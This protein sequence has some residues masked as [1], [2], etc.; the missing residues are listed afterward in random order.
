MASSL[1][2]YTWKSFHCAYRIDRAEENSDNNLG[3]LLIHPIGVGLSGAFWERFSQLWLSQGYKTSI[4]NPDLL[5]CG[6]SDM[7]RMAYYPSDWA[8]QLNFFLETV[9][10]TPVVLVVQGALFPVAIELV[11]NQPQPNYIKGLILSGPPTWGLISEAGNEWQQKLVWNLFFDTPA[12][13]AFYRYARRRQF[14]ES[15]SKKQLFAEAEA[16]DA[17]WLDN[18]E[19]GAANPDSRYAVFS[20]LAGFWRQNYQAAIAKITQPTL[21]VVGEKA[22]SISR[23]GD[24]ET[25]ATRL[26]SY[27]KH[28][29]NGKGCQISGRNVPPY[30][31]TEEFVAV[32]AE[33]LEGTGEQ[34]SRGTGEQGRRGDRETGRRGDQ[35]TGSI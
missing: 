2:Y 31:S 6:A 30:E 22:S 5:G 21:V 35:E 32:V 8:A 28:L 10:K 24:S 29:P 13:N 20:F 3:L 12:G 33:F 34:G 27:L 25:P 23:K 9:V 1:Q 19:R 18:L 14:L 17:Q 11:N 16:V 7:P 15:F 26:Q 4:Y